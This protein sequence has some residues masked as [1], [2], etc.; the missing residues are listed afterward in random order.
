MLMY[1][2]SHLIKC[3]RQKCAIIQ[4]RIICIF[5]TLFELRFA[6]LS[7]ATLFFFI[8]F[9]DFFQKLLPRPS[10]MSDFRG[11]I[12]FMTHTIK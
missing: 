9:L 3:S 12:V 5:L 1:P 6:A 11:T 7:Q 2:L 10:E 8:F 4:N